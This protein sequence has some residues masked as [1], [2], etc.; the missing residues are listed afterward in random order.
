MG[1]GGRGGASERSTSPDV[2]PAVEGRGGSL[3]D[4]GDSSNFGFVTVNWGWDRLWSTGGWGG[5]E[6]ELGGAYIGW[7]IAGIEGPWGDAGI[8]GKGFGA[9][10]AGESASGTPVE[11]KED[12]EPDD[13]LS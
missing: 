8:V 10:G 11:G 5:G 2:A 9:I 3:G 12:A 7:R 6:N 4:S 13:G 1:N